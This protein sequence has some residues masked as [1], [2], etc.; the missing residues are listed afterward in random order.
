[1]FSLYPS[2]SYQPVPSL[3][4]LFAWV[5]KHTGSPRAPHIHRYSTATG[6]SYADSVRKPMDHGK[7]NGGANRG[8]PNNRYGGSSIGQGA[9]QGALF[10]RGGLPP[11][12]RGFYLGY[13]GRGQ[14]AGRGVGR[15]GQRG[16]PGGWNLF[17][18]PRYDRRV[19]G[20]DGDGNGAA[21]G[22]QDNHRG[23]SG[24]GNDNAG[25]HNQ[26]EQELRDN[27]H[28]Q[29]GMPREAAQPKGT[30]DT[31]TVSIGGSNFNLPAQAASLLQKAFEAM[32][33]TGNVKP[34]QEGIGSAGGDK[35]KTVATPE[36]IE[37]LSMANP[38]PDIPESSYQ[39]V[40][41]KEGGGKVP[42]CF[43][44]KTKRTCNRRVPC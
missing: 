7:A 12:T 20:A 38:C 11:A 33:E 18:R 6:T 24:V 8:V 44:C 31:G 2:V 40:A 16:R 41:R 29:G 37:H 42:Y 19:H 32:K 10:G 43:R 30:A 23:V 9:G 5:G 25:N 36:V 21:G 27:K 26:Q 1:V 22:V 13:V 15:Y 39:A 3:V 17:Y 4:A 34:Q 35:G 14:F 28:Q